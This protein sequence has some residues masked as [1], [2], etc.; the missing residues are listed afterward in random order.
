[1]WERGAGGGRNPGAR[2]PPAG[3]YKF[4]TKYPRTVELTGKFGWPAVPPAIEQAALILTGRLLK[5]GRETPYG[6]LGL[7]LDGAA[8]RINRTDP[9][10]QTL[11]APFVR[12][13][14]FR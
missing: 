8:V 2:R 10:V 7:G 13:M 4:T 12:T 14:P 9:D 5:R 11:A 1:M 3:N 6:V